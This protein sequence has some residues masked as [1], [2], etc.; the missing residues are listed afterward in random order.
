MGARPT[1]R[2]FGRAALEDAVVAG[3]LAALLSGLP[4]TAWALA[5]GRDPFEA[6]L[7][8][9]SLALPRETRRA[10]LLVAAVP[11][12][13]AASLGWA[14]V[15]G[16][17]LPRRRTTVAGALAGVAIAGVDLAAAGRAFPRIRALP[18]APQLA[19]HV[20][21]GAVVGTVLGRRRARR[22]GRASA[23]EG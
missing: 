7:A 1:R 11:V 22:H 3:G 19:D 14:L 16:A 5:T 20:A 12:H 9:G 18:L 10:R 6:T 21:Y 23:S 13:L 4:S 8:A 17:V 2:P 15:L